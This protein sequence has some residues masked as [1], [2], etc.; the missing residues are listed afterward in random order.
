MYVNQGEISR[1][2]YSPRA[3]GV[4]FTFLRPKGLMVV[5]KAKFYAEFRNSF[6]IKIPS[7]RFSQINFEVR[8][9]Y[10]RKVPICEKTL[11]THKYQM[12]P[13]DLI[14]HQNGHVMYHLKGI[15][16]LVSYHNELGETISH[17]SKEI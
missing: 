5:S 13:K 17:N 9:P 12:V 3:E 14:H 15:S 6:F 7:P 1:G 11:L 2:L 4:L 8:Y 10:N 16:L